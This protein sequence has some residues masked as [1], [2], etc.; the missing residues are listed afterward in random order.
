MLFRSRHYTKYHRRFFSYI[1]TYANDKRR[2][3][4]KTNLPVDWNIE[5]DEKKLVESRLHYTAHKKTRQIGRASD[6]LN[7][8]FAAATKLEYCTGIDE[9][10][11]KLGEKKYIIK[12][13][14]TKFMTLKNWGLK[15]VKELTGKK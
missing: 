8:C 7:S 9:R 6:I 4:E 13:N 11:N 12:L 10:I 14:R 3:E 1:L 15:D 5:V 2:I